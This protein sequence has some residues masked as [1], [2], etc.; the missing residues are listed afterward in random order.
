[1][2]YTLTIIMTFL[3]Y[4]NYKQKNGPFQTLSHSIKNEFFHRIPNEN[5][6][7]YIF[8]RFILSFAFIFQSLFDL[9]QN[10]TTGK[11][12]SFYLFISRDARDIV[13]L[14]PSYRDKFLDYIEDNLVR[15]KFSHGGIKVKV[16]EEELEQYCLS[17]GITSP[18]LDGCFEA[19]E[20]DHGVE[21]NYQNVDTPFKIHY[22]ARLQ[23]IMWASGRRERLRHMEVFSLH[24][25][26]SALCFQG[27][28]IILLSM[29][30]YEFQGR[31]NCQDESRETFFF[32]FLYIN[33]VLFVL[34]SF[35]TLSEEYCHK[36]LH[37]VEPIWFLTY[38]ATFI[39]Y[40]LFISNVFPNLNAECTTLSESDI[41]LCVF[42]ASLFQLL[43][44]MAW[45]VWII[46]IEKKIFSK[47]M[48]L[49]CRCKNKDK[50]KQVM[51][52]QGGKLE[53][54]IKNNMK[55][56]L[57]HSVSRRKS[58]IGRIASVHRKKVG[59]ASHKK[60][61]SSC[62]AFRHAIGTIID[63]FCVVICHL[64]LICVIIFP[65]AFFY[66]QINVAQQ[67][68]YSKELLSLDNF[69]DNLLGI[70]M[71]SDSELSEMVFNLGIFT[72][73]IAS[74]DL[75]LYYIRGK[76]SNSIMRTSST[77]SQKN[78]YKKGTVVSYIDKKKRK[79]IGKIKRVD[80][81]HKGKMTL[82]STSGEFVFIVAPE[83]T[84]SITC[85]GGRKHYDD[86]ND[87]NNNETE[88]SNGYINIHSTL[89]HEEEVYLYKDLEPISK[90]RIIYRR[91]KIILCCDHRYSFIKRLRLLLHMLRSFS[92][93]AIHTC[94]IYLLYLEVGMVC[95]MC[96]LYLVWF[97]LGVIVLP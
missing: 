64:L 9:I 31:D 74:L 93:N 81:Q 53:K 95:S 30:F 65:F 56:I 90:F 54:K 89:F 7:E 67:I 21:L 68:F 97:M 80:F 37:I 29:L 73:F 20:H 52:E 12:R 10:P 78:L 86:K 8:S 57:K 6:F 25:F 45:L 55:E 59:K 27:L 79:R 88:R 85:C 15:N 35:L 47:Y 70:R 58:L 2:R 82:N 36:C 87:S 33:A 92:H 23:N 5:L 60:H 40:I 34:T 22:E 14:I 49:I 1:M 61:R 91:F 46:E 63:E 69:W 19:L 77:K 17:M 75:L 43:S 4:N 84:H 51:P 3:H 50:S 96:F 48:K 39:L 42:F 62:T 13:K 94:L 11:W 76:G 24:N 44:L 16:F 71:G 72:F 83:R 32:A 26:S 18:A 28:S 38:I 66:F 41:F